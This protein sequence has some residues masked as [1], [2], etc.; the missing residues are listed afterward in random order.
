[1][2]LKSALTITFVLLVLTG[3]SGAL[4]STK[5]LTSTS[6]AASPFAGTWQTTWK[7][8]D[9]SS[10]AAH[11]VVKADSLEPNSLDGT[12]EMKG[13]NGVM[14]GAVSAE[15]KT[16]SGNWWSSKAEK[17]TFTFTLKQNRNF[18]GSYTLDGT[19][20]SFN[21]NGTK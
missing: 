4:T 14:Y 9:G 6:P 17:G 13:P 7:N 3:V 1:M 20:G 21:W 2:R 8:A 5:S 18:E 15:G 12:M 11:V 16:W 19:T 10:G